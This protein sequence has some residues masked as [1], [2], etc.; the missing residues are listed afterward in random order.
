[1]IIRLLMTIV[2]AG[3]VLLIVAFLAATVSA[4]WDKLSKHEGKCPKCRGT[5]WVAVE[6]ATKRACDCGAIS[7]DAQAPTIDVSK[8]REEG[9]RHRD[10]G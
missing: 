9:K 6:E 10:S 4:L 3:L 2:I 1:M 8:G 5:G 7:A